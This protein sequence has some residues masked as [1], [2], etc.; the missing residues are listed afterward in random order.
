MTTLLQGAQQFH[1]KKRMS[2][3]VLKEL[4]AK[5]FVKLVWFVVQQLIGES[6]FIGFA[7]LAQVQRHV[8]RIAFDFCQHLF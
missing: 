2:S 4:L 1:R 3:G 5:G 8:A 6:S 7:G